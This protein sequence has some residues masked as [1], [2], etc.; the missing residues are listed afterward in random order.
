[1]AANKQTGQKSTFLSHKIGFSV[2]QFF[3]TLGLGV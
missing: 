2:I 3:R 1:M